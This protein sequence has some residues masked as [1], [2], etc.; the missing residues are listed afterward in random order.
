MDY[1]VTPEPEPEPEPP[2][3]KPMATVGLFALGFVLAFVMLGLGYGFGRWHANELAGDEQPAVGVEL[4]V[5]VDAT[6]NRHPD[7]PFA[8]SAAVPVETEL[9]TIW[10]S[11]STAYVDGCGSRGLNAT[12]VTAALEAAGREL[13]PGVNRWGLSCPNSDPAAPDTTVPPP[14]RGG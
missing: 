4:G 3:R 14:T 12:T 13:P 9:G 7:A 8:P 1:Y 6:T 11:G 5:E 2:D 10:I